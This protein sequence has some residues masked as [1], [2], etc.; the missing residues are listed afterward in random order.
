MNFYIPEYI[1]TQ[2][3]QVVIRHSHYR[4]IYF[5]TLTYW[6]MCTEGKADHELFMLV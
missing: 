6:L 1:L 5:K 4:L 3:I 2:N